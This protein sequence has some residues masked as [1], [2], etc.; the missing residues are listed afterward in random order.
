MQ[1]SYRPTTE[2]AII[3][4]A[5]DVLS[6]DPSASL[7]DIAARAGVGRATL[8]RHFAGRAELVRALALLAIKEMDE[9]AQAASADATSYAA[10]LQ[11]MLA[12][13]IPLGSRHGFLAVE[14]DIDDPEITAAFA[15]QTEETRQMVDAAKAEGSF[16][17]YVPTD[18]IVQAF[19]HLIYAAWES[20]KGGEVTQAQ[21]STLAWRTLTAGLGPQA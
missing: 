2:A 5:F 6:R 17:Q 15:K 11:Q 7:A 20:V 14:P 13:M 19:D 16:D 18:W 21:A 1:S 9:A 10:A 12:A 8:H 4:A 3:E